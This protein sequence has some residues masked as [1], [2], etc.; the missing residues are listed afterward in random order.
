[1]GKASTPL[2]LRVENVTEEYLRTATPGQGAITYDPGYDV[3]RHQAEVKFS[4]WL[5]RTFGGDIQLLNESTIEGEKRADYLWRDHLWDLKDVSSEKAAN[6]AIKR[7]LSQIKQNPGGIILNYGE[8]EI[9]PNV[10]L[11]VIDKRMQW[12]KDGSSVDIMIVLKDRLMKILR[13]NRNG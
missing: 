9:T 5:H 7:G 4:K 3:Q 12:L 1:M 2:P 6:T 13:Y 11:D 8:Q 10:L